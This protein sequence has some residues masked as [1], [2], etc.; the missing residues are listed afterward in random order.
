MRE[1]PGHLAVDNGW[2]AGVVAFQCRGGIGCGTDNVLGL[3][4]KGWV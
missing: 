2:I 3:S 4:R 1:R